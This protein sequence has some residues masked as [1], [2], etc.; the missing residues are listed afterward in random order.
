M[1]Q[2]SLCLSLCVSLSLS[3]SLSLCLSLSLSPVLS[4][5]RVSSATL[6]NSVSR[7]VIF[8]WGTL[9]G[10]L[11]YIHWHCSLTTRLGK[12]WALQLLSQG[13]ALTAAHRSDVLVC[14]HFSFSCR[15]LHSLSFSAHINKIIGEKSYRCSLGTYLGSDVI[16]WKLLYVEGSSMPEKRF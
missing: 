10:N 14:C 9:E 5:K 13:F 16:L 12:N 8:S 3:P 15:K 6:K 1:Q 11:I 7:C 4:S 2:F